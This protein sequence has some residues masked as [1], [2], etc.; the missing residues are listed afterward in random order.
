MQTNLHGIVE[1]T[2]AVGAK[3]VARG[4]G[5]KIVMIGSLMSLLGLPYLTVYAMTKSAHRGP[6]AGRWRRSGDATAFR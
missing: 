5:G 4:K 2:Q 6:D 3:M 1:L